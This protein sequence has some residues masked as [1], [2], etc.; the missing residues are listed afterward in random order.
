VGDDVTDQGLPPPPVVNFIP[1]RVDHSGSLPRRSSA[2]NPPPQPQQ[3]QQKREG[4][5]SGTAR[6]MPRSPAPPRKGGAQEEGGDQ[7]LLAKLDNIRQE[8]ENLGQRINNFKVRQVPW[9]K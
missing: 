4:S 2:K 6:T 1:I 5:V 8:V 3:Q 7:A 9:F